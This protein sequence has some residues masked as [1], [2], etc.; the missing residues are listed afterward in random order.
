MRRSLETWNGG[1]LNGH[2]ERQLQS[3][4]RQRGGFGGPRLAPGGSDHGSVLV[5]ELALLASLIKRLCSVWKISIWVPF[6][7]HEGFTE[8]E[9][10]KWKKNII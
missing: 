2:I 3:S 8:S 5:R 9:I 1:G 7:N 6:M 4:L 10:E